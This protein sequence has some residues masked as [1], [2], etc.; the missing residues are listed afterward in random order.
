[1]LVFEE[2]GKQ[3]VLGE[4]PL[5]A[6]TTTKNSTHIRRQLRDS[7]RGTLLGGEGAHNCGIPAPLHFTCFEVLLSLISPYSDKNV[8]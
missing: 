2:R 5:G 6:R 8:K 4:R 7:N 3:D 1:M